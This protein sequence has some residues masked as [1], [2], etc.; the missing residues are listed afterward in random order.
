MQAATLGC[1]A[2]AATVVASQ[3][4][5][6]PAADAAFDAPKRL[7]TLVGLAIA[8]AAT[9]AL[10]H[11]FADRGRSRAARAVAALGGLAAL[12]IVV[13]ATVSPRPSASLD[14]LRRLG[15]VALALPIGASALLDGAG[16]SWIVRA[17]VAAAT[18]N[19]I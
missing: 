11:P 16:R 6:D 9:A 13:A 4:L 18:G 12:A 14:A 1:G 15:L 8:A 5:V 10:P 2:L 17:F 7:A 3:W 19:A